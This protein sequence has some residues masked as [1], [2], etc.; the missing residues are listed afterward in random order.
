[1][2]MNLPNKLTIFRILMIPV[3][4]VLFFVEFEG[5]TLAA[6]L[7]YV[8][9]C[10]T[11]FF[12]GYIARKQNLVTNFGK[13]VDPIADKMIIACSLIAICVTE[14]IVAPAH[15]Y[16]I[17]VAVF[18][19]LILSRELMI[20][21]FRTVAADKGVVLAAD[22]IG[23]FKTLVQMMALFALL[24]VADFV[25]WNEL[26][27]IVFYYGGFILLSIATLLTVISGVH[28]IVKNRSVLE[29]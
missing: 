1:M 25:V 3:F 23:K 8:V 11:D 28:Y 15:V 4:I 18:T 5:H 24:P 27:G 13:F 16:K 12:D 6:A 10:F 21:V 19:M 29:G 2:K 14:P 17:L 7:V 22:M 9:A 20:S 26:A